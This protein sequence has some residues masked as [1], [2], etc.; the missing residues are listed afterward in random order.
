[1]LLLTSLVAYMIPDVPLKL[2]K[3]IRLEKSL[4]SH[5]IINT[6][7]DRAQGHTGAVNLRGILSARSQ[8]ADN[9][10]ELCALISATDN[11]A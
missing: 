3:Q 7:L 5:M 8:S 4:I 9:D 11:I 10:A 1:M 6:E 2:Q